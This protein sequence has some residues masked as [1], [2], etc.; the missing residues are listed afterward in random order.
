[1]RRTGLFTFTVVAVLSLSLAACKKDSKKKDAAKKEPAAGK[2]TE[3]PKPEPKP[4]PVTGEQLA[5]KAA[6]C[7]SAF[8]ANDMPKFFG[9]FAPGAEAGPVDAVPPMRGP[10]EAVVTG[11]KTAIPDLKCAQNLTL[12][13]GNRVVTADLCTGTN[14]G[15]MMG[16]PPTNKKVGWQAAHVFETNEEGLVAT[17]YTYMDQSTYAGQ[18]GMHKMPHRKAAAAP[19][20]NGPV[21][22]GKGGDE[23]AK[24]GEW[25]KTW[26]EAWNA[27][28]L[29]KLSAMI[30]DD[31]VMM[32][33]AMPA[34]TKGGKGLSAELGAYFKAFPDAKVETQWSFGAGDYVVQGVKYSGTNKGAAKEVGIPK[35]TGKSAELQGLEIYQIA[36]GKVKNSWVYYNGMA[37]M[38]QLGL[39]QPPAAPPAEGAKGGEQPKKDEAA[40]PATK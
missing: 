23:D 34:D 17:A 29:K 35:A 21:A 13:S 36:D 4:E 31:A 39:V 11:F 8:N 15:P 22:V 14:S 19:S 12:V 5:A 30:A 10:A 6:E 16:A 9:C 2:T 25:V 26:G 20:G 33:A 32:D 24:A 38:V 18:L 7:W 1:M 40:E 28:D 37:M 27:H 3:E